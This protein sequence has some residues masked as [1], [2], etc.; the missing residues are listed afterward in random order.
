[1]ALA[2]HLKTEWEN[3]WNNQ[4]EYEYFQDE[5]LKRQFELQQNLGT[6]ALDEND[7]ENVGTYSNGLLLTCVI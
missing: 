6:A 4:F 3:F 7:F 5:A 1:M 2:N